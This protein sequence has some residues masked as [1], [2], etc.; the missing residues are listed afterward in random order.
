MKPRRLEG[1]AKKEWLIT[2]RERVEVDML[3]SERE[4]LRQK[5]SA[6]GGVKPGTIRGVETLGAW[7]GGSLLGGARVKGAEVMVLQ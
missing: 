3:Q 6:H 1:E 5:Y 2:K 7:V 4:A